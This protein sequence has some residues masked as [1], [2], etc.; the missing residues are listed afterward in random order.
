VEVRNKVNHAGNVLLAALRELL[1]DFR[2]KPVVVDGQLSKEFNEAYWALIKLRNV[3]CDVNLQI[4]SESLDVELVASYCDCDDQRDVTLWFPL[5]RL[6]WN[7]NL[8]HFVDSGDPFKTDYTE[9]RVNQDMRDFV[10]ARR[11]IKELNKSVWQFR[12]YMDDRFGF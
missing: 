8:A 9:E 3:G 11:I 10:K 12:N 5:C 6:Y 7:G 2:D 4:H 1:K